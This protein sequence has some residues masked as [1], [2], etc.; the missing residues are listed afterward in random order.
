MD[1]L[2]FDQPSPDLLEEL[3]V[4]RQKINYHNYLYNT[5]DQP[6]ISDYEYD[7]LFNRLKEI[8]RNYPELITP[9]SPTQKVGAKPS[10]RFHKVNHPAQVLSLTNAFGPQE[11]LDWYNRLLRIEPELDTADFVLEPKL[12]GLTV[13]L[14]YKNGIFTLGATRGDG[15]IGEDITDNLRTIPSLPLRIPVKPGVNV[16]QEIV[17]RGEVL[18][19]KEDFIKLNAELE[20]KGE[21]TYLNP[22]NTAAGSLRQLDPS[23]TANR[24]LKLFV[25]QILHSSGPIPDTQE[26]ILDYIKALGIPFNSLRWHADNIQDAI[27]ICESQNTAR[28]DW[29]FEAD[30]IVIKINDQSLYN[31]LGSIGKDARGAVA[32]KYPGEVVETSLLDIQ[33]NVGRTGVITP[34]AILEPVMV[35]GVVVKQATLHNFDFIA[36]KDIRIGDRVLIKRAGE[37]IPYIIATLPEK[38]DGS[39]ISYNPPATC[40]SC[41]TA[42]I[43]DAEAVAWYCENV[44]C[45]AQLN[46]TIENYVSRT[47]MDIA[48][49]GEKIVV[50][51]TKAGL[52]KSI[53][54]LYTLE[55]DEL[56]KLDKFG[57]LKAS[58]LLNAIEASKSQSLQRLIIGLGI[59]GIGEVS[60][61]DLARHFKSLDSLS[62]ANLDELQIISGIGPNTAESIVH[63]FAQIQNQET[64]QRLKNY[65]VWPII[66]DQP[67]TKSQKPLEGLTFVIS[68]ALPNMTRDEAKLLIE[69][70]GGKTTG[71]VSKKT[72]YLLLGENP[73]S[74]LDKALELG[75]PTI[76]EQELKN[77]LQLF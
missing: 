61:G 44:N 18:I 14:H 67:K 31:I 68:G 29:P 34:L 63:W 65:G 17:F 59:H 77:L 19:L 23:I 70:N 16:P 71:S 5:L 69:S 32:Y 56:L 60:A 54:D 30:G 33:N 6:E 22:R 48:G 51:L 28:H 47:A 58:N 15:L 52:L 36:D 24:P 46:R 27:A 2:P 45:P 42:L 20:A 53:A 39:Q 21:K 73:G 25:Y 66:Q 40:P 74:K 41:G 37:V 10:E 72:N 64:L 8:E 26:S 57:E 7:Q 76:N 13:V 43:K 3:K 49:L 4:L 75:I 62:Q 11:T 12:D 38:R 50:Q 35:G 9:D 55:K 1:Q